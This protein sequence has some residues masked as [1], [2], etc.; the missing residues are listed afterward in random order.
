MCDT[1]EHHH[2]HDHDHHPMS[3]TI[4]GKSVHETPFLLIG[5]GGPVGTGKTTLVE[6]MCQIL[7]PDYRIGVVTNDIYTKEDARILTELSGLDPLR[8]LGVET[9]GCPHHAIRD[10]VSAN[11]EAVET[12]L[13]RNDDQLDL[14][15]IE[16][17][18]DNLAASFSPEL[19]DVE[20]YVID[21]SGGE[22]IPR[23]GGPGIM[24]SNLLII[25]KI[26]LAPYVGASLEVMESDSRKMR[27]ERPFL[28]TDLR[29][30]VGITDLKAWIET[31]I[32]IKKQ[33]FG[34]EMA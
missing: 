26:D 10:D 8:I 23:K 13:A 30:G 14:I 3:P 28:M 24:H 25:N 19:I 9:G 4:N 34:T 32:T 33:A 15:F 31:Q 12:L 21:V 7:A 18:G 5:V 2:H 27:D 17:G 29:N 16:S 20:I 6:K 22:K 1:H 11:I